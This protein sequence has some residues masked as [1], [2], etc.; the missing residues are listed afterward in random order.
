MWILL[1]EVDAHFPDLF[2][3]IILATLNSNSMYGGSLNFWRNR[4]GKCALP[5]HSGIS[6]SN[7]WNTN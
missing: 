7:G 6:F 2:A 1:C 5:L 3:P 4:A